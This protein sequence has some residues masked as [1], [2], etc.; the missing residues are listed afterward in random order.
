MFYI[1]DTLY[2][3]SKKEYGKNSYKLP[4]I[5]ILNSV[6]KYIDDFS[7]KHLRIKKLCVVTEKMLCAISTFFERLWV[8]RN[9]LV[10]F[11]DKETYR[12]LS[13]IIH[14]DIH[15]LSNQDLIYYIC[16]LEKYGKKDLNTW[17]FEERPRK[18]IG[19]LKKIWYNLTLKAY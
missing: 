14:D 4:W 15:K 12:I 19:F 11:S 7:D 6:L 3:Y 5:D 17:G 8:K 16:L 9:H 13:P 18:K 2:G 1:G 10:D